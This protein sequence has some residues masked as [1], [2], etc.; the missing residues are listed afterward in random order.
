MDMMN[1]GIEFDLSLDLIKGRNFSWN[2]ALNGTHYKNKI[3]KLPSD[4]PEEGKQIGSYW[5]E[6][7]GSLYNYYMY[8]W[9]GVDPETGHALY[10]KY[11]VDEATGKPTDEFEKTVTSTSEATYR[12]TGKTP[13]PDLYG[14]FSTTLHFYGFD[15]SANFAYQLGG[16]TNDSVYQGLMTAGR[17]GNNWSRDIFNRWTPTNTGSQIPRVQMNDQTA[18]ESSTRWLTSSSYLSIRNV[19]LGYTIPKNLTAKVGLEG[20]RIYV[21][22]DNLWYISARRGMDVRK[23]FDGS[24]ANTYSALRTISGG[25]SLTF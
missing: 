21:T 6:L 20:V 10:N 3:T 7:G 16:W 5:R 12:K 25:I 15:F 13:I 1:T 17:A 19:T 24:N 8:E 11:K 9:A 4:Y 23:S 14:G 22:A 2:V 18:N